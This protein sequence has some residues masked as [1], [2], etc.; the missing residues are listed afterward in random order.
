MTGVILTGLLD[1]G[2]A[3]LAEIKGRGGIA[4]VQDP[5]T[6]LFPSMPHAAL[7]HVN[8]DHIVPLEQIAPLVSKLVT[9]QR[10]A[11]VKYEWS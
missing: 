5:S 3:G 11:F 9:T 10:V 1:D 4:I 8:V 7:W 6:A 2:A